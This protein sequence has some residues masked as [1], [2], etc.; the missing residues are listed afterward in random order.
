[1]GAI[2]KGSCDVRS[3]GI[4][5]LV[6]RASSDVGDRIVENARLSRKVCLSC[7]CGALFLHRFGIKP[8]ARNV[9]SVPKVARS[10]ATLATS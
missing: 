1:M 10:V 7:L 6:S 8:G 4:L 9:D 5:E 3:L 2:A